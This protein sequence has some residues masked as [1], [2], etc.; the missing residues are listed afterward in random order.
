MI[1]QM[2]VTVTQRAVDLCSHGLGEH[3]SS[4]ERRIDTG[5]NWTK[6]SAR[7][8]AIRGPDTVDLLQERHRASFLVGVMICVSGPGREAVRVHSPKQGPTVGG[9]VRGQWNNLLTAGFLLSSC[10]HI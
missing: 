8:K 3:G 4:R 7:K 9:R 10:S 2:F 5:L 1:P 6:K